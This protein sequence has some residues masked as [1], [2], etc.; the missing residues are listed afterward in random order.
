MTQ[1]D[2]DPGELFKLRKEE[3][4]LNE[5]KS[6]RKDVVDPQTLQQLEA[7]MKKYDDAVNNNDAGAV[8]ALYV[9]DAVFVTDLGT[10]YGPQGVKQWYADLFKKWHPKSHISK[11]DPNSTRFIGTTD[12]VMLSG[13]WSESGEGPKGDT[14]EIKGYWSAI[15]TRVGDA[16]KIRML[17]L[18]HL[19]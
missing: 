5:K 7:K 2:P 18:H 1:F 10:V 17:A 8:A 3:K 14:I 11:R 12:Y 13:E 16:W 9:E 19:E 15:D 4:D 6:V